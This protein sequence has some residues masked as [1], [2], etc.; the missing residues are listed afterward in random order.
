[1]INTWGVTPTSFAEPDGGIDRIVFSWWPWVHRTNAGGRGQRPAAGGTRSRRSSAPIIA[2]RPGRQ[3]ARCVRVES[4]CPKRSWN[5]RLS[6]PA[7]A[8]QSLIFFFLFFFSFFPFLL[9]FFRKRENRTN[10]DRSRCEL[11]VLRL[12]APAYDKHSCRMGI[13]KNLPQRHT[14]TRRLSSRTA[15]RP[16]NQAWVAAFR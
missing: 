10:S 2:P 3:S 15:A 16:P 5:M 11:Q 1:M 4:C 7:C 9:F 12:A 6:A 8:R 13:Q 14:A